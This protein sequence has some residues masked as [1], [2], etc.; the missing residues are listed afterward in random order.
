MI[1][2][3]DCEVIDF[4]KEYKIATTSTLEH[5]FFPSRRVAQRRLKIL[6]DGKYIKRSQ[7]FI[8]EDYYYYLTKPKQLRHSVMITEFYREFSKYHHID[9][10]QIQKKLENII[11][12]AL[13]GYTQNNKKKVAIL[14]IELS[15]KGFDYYK[16]R[17]FPH[18]KYFNTYPN[19][20]IVTKQRI[21]RDNNINFIQI[22]DINND[23]EQLFNQ[24]RISAI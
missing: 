1:T 7:D 4:L 23:L 24:K 3:R 11:P 16:Y 12:D 14:E 8:K 10:F 20:Y 19:V 21:E 5:F 17:N 9:Y 6:A 18:T 2:K 15:N 13:I 22:R